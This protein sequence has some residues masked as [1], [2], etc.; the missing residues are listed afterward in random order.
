MNLLGKFLIAMPQMTD[1]NFE[2]SVVYIFHQNEKGTS[3]VVINR[4]TNIAFNEV[5]DKFGHRPIFEDV[6]I[7]WGGPVQSE[8]GII[9]HTNEK[10]WETTLPIERNL[11]YSISADLLESVS[12]G[13]G[14]KK[15]LVT[16]GYAGWEKGQ[17]E[18]EI[19]NDCWLVGNFRSRIL[20]DLAPEKRYR[21]ALSA[22][23]LDPSI[24]I[25]T[26]GTVGHA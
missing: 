22:L 17:L 23:G 16:L 25:A 24:F 7:F 1:P 3:G 6:P 20:F 5:L 15:F 8:Q 18:S 9:I 2:G 26:E 10:I 14:P 19:S 4:P 12:K 21:A 11:C 13:E